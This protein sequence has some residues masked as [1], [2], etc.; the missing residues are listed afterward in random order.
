MV[1]GLGERAAFETAFQKLLVLFGV[2]GISKIVPI[3][4]N[5]APVIRGDQATRAARRR[6]DGIGG[7]GSGGGNGCELMRRRL[8]RIRTPDQGSFR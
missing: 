5:H 3:S 7:E 2:V 8:L 1:K 4:P 6:E